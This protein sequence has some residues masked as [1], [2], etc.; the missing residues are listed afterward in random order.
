MGQFHFFAPSHE[1]VPVETLASAYLAGMEGIPWRSANRWNHPEG[2]SPVAFSLDRSIT[3]SG[4]LNIPWQ[5]PGIGELMLSTASLMETSA[6]YNLPLEL[7][8][9]VVNRLRNQLAD[10][11]M[12]GLA[13]PDALAS[14]IRNASQAFVA[15]ITS[16]PDHASAVAAS[17]KAIRLAL[18]AGEAL[19]LEYTRQALAA[20]HQNA[21]HLPTL[22]GCRLGSRPIEGT[23]VEC[24]TSGF[25]TAVVPF[26]W[27]AIEQNAGKHEWE[28]F[29]QQISW[30]QENGLRVIGGP[31]LQLDAQHLPD[32][33]YLWE[34]DFE[35]VQSYLM[36]YIGATVSRYRGRVQVWN[37]AARM[38]IGGAISLSEEQRLRLMVAAVSELRRNDPQTPIVLS[39]DQP[40]AEY[41]AANDRDLS[42]LHLADSLVR[43]DLGIS[44]VGIEFNI[45][46]QPAGSAPRE[47]VEYSRQ[48]DRWAVLG[49]PL[50]AYISYP[51]SSDVNTNASRAV[52]YSSSER[53]PEAQSEFANKLIPLILAKSFVQG[54]IW[55]ETSDAEPHEFANAGII[56]A[57]GSPKP[58]LDSLVALRKQHLT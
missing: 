11:R 8:R 43:A 39:F 23:I 9:G 55:N 25:N 44:G 40:W 37:C 5:I 2:S 14:E 53:T 1:Q 26:T 4:N 7:A 50:I 13:V 27:R 57:T 21:E 47:L 45:G 6:P 10:W 3:E 24:L 52:R 28:I 56:D 18:Q 35:Q 54:I 49:L 33:L 41:L 19:C 30:C 16:L 20:R 29:D 34:D 46:Y 48:L 15:A 31:L 32:W 58:L 36:Q 12:A 42:P 17:E 22:L 51:S 38:N